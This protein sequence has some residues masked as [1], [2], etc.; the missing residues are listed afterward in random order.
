MADDQPLLDVRQMLADASPRPVAERLRSLLVVAR[1][2]GSLRLDPA[3]GGEG[4]GFGEVEWEVGCGPGGDGYGSL[5]TPLAIGP[6][7]SMDCAGILTPPGIQLP[8]IVA[9]PD[10]VYRQ[11]FVGAGGHIRRVSLIQAPRYG[12][13]F[14]ELHVMSS[15]EVKA[16]RTSLTSLP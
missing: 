12:R 2:P 3:L 13:S 16:P 5:D 4:Q 15:A 6:G 11:R 1:K 7:T 10:G 8:P 14:M 9:P